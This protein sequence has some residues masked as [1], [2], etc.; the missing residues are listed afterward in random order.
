[1]NGRK[2]YHDRERVRKGEIGRNR[3]I[4]K[5]ERINTHNLSYNSY[6]QLFL[7]LILYNT[8][9]FTIHG[10]GNLQTLHFTIGGLTLLDFNL[11]KF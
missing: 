1:M 3:E 9:P 4:T 11:D 2:V 7:I 8:I 5:N 6:S 10:G